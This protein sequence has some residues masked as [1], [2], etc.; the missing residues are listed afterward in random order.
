M[1]NFKTRVF[2]LRVIT[3]SDTDYDTADCNG[4]QWLT[5]EITGLLDGQIGQVFV[6]PA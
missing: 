1:T 2:Q 3:S 4:L 5:E 6:K